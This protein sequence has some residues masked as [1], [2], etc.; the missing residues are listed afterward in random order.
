MAGKKE[1]VRDMFNGIA[2]RYDFLNHFLSA[3]IDKSWRNKLVKKA[4][5]GKHEY[6]LD[7]A[8]GTGDLA[9]VLSKLPVKKI[10]GLD[11][12]VNMLE[13]AKGKVKELKKD[14]LIEFIAGDS[15]N[16]PF[17]DNS[18]DLVTVAFGVRNFEDLDKGLGE[19]LR[20]LK[21]GGRALILEFSTVTAFPLKHLYKFYS[22][23]ILPLMGRII[24][25]HKE[26]YTYLPESVAAFPWGTGFLKHLDSVG[27]IKTSQFRLSG[28]I[29]TLYEG[30]KK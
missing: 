21:P 13:I 4:A 12:A 20:V 18:F 2:G 26:A 8:T 1:A 14:Q 17:D 10:I 22:K 16:L 6:I 25:G 5:S 15:E 23:Y 27:Y 30:V 9:I 24:S 11:I 28:G 29:A 7:V 3:G 19:M